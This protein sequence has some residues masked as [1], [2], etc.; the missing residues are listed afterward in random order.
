MKINRLLKLLQSTIIELEN[1][2]LQLTSFS[3]NK[4]T[5]TF[6]SP[7]CS[8]CRHSRLLSTRNLPTTCCSLGMIQARKSQCNSFTSKKIDQQCQRT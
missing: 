5:Q 7:Y 6:I 4:T 8:K 1:F 2:K 3:A